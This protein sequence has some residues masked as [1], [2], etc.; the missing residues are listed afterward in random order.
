MLI[1]QLESG[2]DA[3]IST[4]KAETSET[5]FFISSEMAR[6]LVLF[7]TKSE[8]VSIEPF[9][10]ESDPLVY[11][12]RL[13]EGWR[14]IPSDSR[15]GLYLALCDHGEIDLGKGLNEGANVWLQGYLK[16]IKGARLKDEIPD[17]VRQSVEFWKRIQERMV[18]PDKSET[19]RT[20]SLQPDESQIWAVVV[21]YYDYSYL[22]SQYPG[23]YPGMTV[24]EGHN[25]LDAMYRMNWGYDGNG[26]DALYSMLYPSWQEYDGDKSII[27]NLVPK[28]LLIQ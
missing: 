5:P 13:N 23:L 6:L 9:P 25:Y 28:G 3:S 26:D 17:N 4:T 19:G 10:S 7:E 12:V 11:T 27:Y 1:T 16:Q 24:Y 20:K 21:K 18:S 15:F 2:A 22:L 14:I 8:P